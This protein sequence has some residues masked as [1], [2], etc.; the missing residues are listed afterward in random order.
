MLEKI[1]TGT[2]IEIGKSGQSLRYYPGILINNNGMEIEMDC[3]IERSL[4]YFIEPL[5][6]LALFGK[7][8]LEI[9]LKGV[10]NDEIDVSVDY[11]IQTFI[12]L[13]KNFGME[14]PPQI[15]ILKRGFKPL[16]GGEVH[17]SLNFVKFLKAV[18]FSNKGKVKKIRGI[19][20]ASKIAIQSL[21]R[22]ISSVREVFNDY[23]SDVWI[24]SDYNKGNKA[25]LSSGYGISL[26]A[27]NLNGAV[28]GVDEVFK[29]DKLSNDE[30]NLPENIGKRCALRLLDEIYYV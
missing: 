12:P 17:I 23:L 4:G 29:I 18:D 2:K 13:L 15:K 3:G 5:I 26:I 1:S 21:N 6:C 7:Q 20:Y 30:E 8:N 24:Y 25:G 16:G 28:V 22:M 19:A 11:L 27:E 9:T 10:T 14:N